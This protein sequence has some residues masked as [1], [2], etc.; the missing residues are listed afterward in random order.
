VAG[1]DDDAGALG[2]GDG[3]VPTE[4]AS[5]LGRRRSATGGGRGSTGGATDDGRGGDGPTVDAARRRAGRAS[6]GPSLAETGVLPADAMLDEEV[7][8][9]RDFMVMAIVFMAIGAAS[10]PFIGGDRGLKLV[11]AASLVPSSAA[12]GWLRTRLRDSRR[13]SAR[14]ITAVACLGIVTCHAAILYFGPFSLAPALL[15]LGIYFFGRSQSRL[16]SDVVYAGCAGGF[17]VIGALTVTGAIEDRGVFRAD[18]VAPGDRVAIL[19]LA[20]V[21][22][23]SA[24]AIARATRRSSIAAIERLQ[25]A[26]RQ[27]HQ[28]EAQLQEVRDD[29]DRALRLGGPGRHTDETFGGYR[30]GVVIGR[31]AMG[32]VYEAVHAVTGAAAAVKLLRPTVLDD[33]DHLQRFLRE[34]RAAGAL[35]SPHV[36][37]LLASSEPADT[38]P[39]LVME[40]LRGRD[41]AELLRAR[42]SLAL[43]EVVELA[44]QIGSALDDARAVSIVHR[45]LKPQNLFR[46]ESGDGPPRWKI[47][48]FGVS[49]LGD[50]SGTLTQGN[51][52]GTP[53][54]MAPEQACGEPVDHRTDLYA[55][56]AICYRAIT[57]R[58]PFS[59]KDVPA[60]L[61]RVVHSTPPRPS[62]LASV[63][64]QIDAVI[65]IGMARRRDDRFAS[66]AELAAAFRGAARGT[67]DPA[68]ARRGEL[69]IA[70]RPWGR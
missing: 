62:Q 26:M 16:V 55:L 38:L 43:D 52:I 31:G 60:I 63:T 32:E 65:A 67:L 5:P 54:Y 33:P 44:A 30:L 41:L 57:G 13:Y 40:R 9:T 68:L 35:S 24:Y 42:R 53:G 66:G 27:V 25:A 34:A 36:V 22:L 7:A 19:L 45:D 49:K 10:L 58:P 4:V 3:D 69:L 59:G 39:Y 61:Y 8:R 17:A 28:R 29:L 12:A 15:L 14:E 2:D 56:T 20:Q 6:A 51:L 18:V 50:Q 1:L 21:G 37:R 47:L 11:V 70:A 48:D 46:D 23:L 64:E